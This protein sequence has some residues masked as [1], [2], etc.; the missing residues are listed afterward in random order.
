MT[1]ECFYLR[2]YVVDCFQIFL[3]VVLNN[4]LFDKKI[5]LTW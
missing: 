3:D 5:T 2:N 1:H 4:L